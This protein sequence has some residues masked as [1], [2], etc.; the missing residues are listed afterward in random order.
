[1]T[2]RFERLDAD[3]AWIDRLTSFQETLLSW[4]QRTDLEQKGLRP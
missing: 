1:M 2:A 4:G 3:E